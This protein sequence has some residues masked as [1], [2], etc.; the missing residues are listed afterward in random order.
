[1]S[2]LEQWGWSPAW[3]ATLKQEDP[4]GAMEPA[5]VVEEQRDGYRLQTGAG[6]VRARMSGRLRQEAGAKE[7]W[8]AVGDWVAAT[9]R[10][11][12]GTATVR[13]TLPRRSVLK[14][15]VTRGTEA[16]VVAANVDTVFVVTSLNFDFNA[17][18]MERFLTLIWEGGA[19]PVI[20]LSKAD[21][22][23]DAESRLAEA[24]AVAPGVAVHA[25]SALDGTGVDA[26]AGHLGAGRTVAL[27]GT[28]GVGKSTLVNHLIGDEVQL[29]RQIRKDAYRG[30]HTTTS[31]RLLLL[32]GGAMLVD[33]PGVREIALWDGD[34]GLQAAFED[35][36]SLVTQCRF[37]DCRH[38]SEPGCAV[39]AAVSDG[40]LAEGRYEAY[41]KLE[42]ELAH[43]E[44]RQGGRAALD[45][46]RKKHKLIEHA[47]KRAREKYR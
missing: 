24:E 5:R 35:V 42:R 12:E 20:V 41:A 14:R 25:L 6:V 7:N 17:R 37:T 16:Q 33:T 30:R 15:R 43:L 23:D 36:A 46:K 9:V 39:Q 4:E 11:D 27:I 8:P 47:R 28:S 34:E 32:E 13:R 18:R 1:M 19:Q 29:V 40:S 10:Q 31:R 26:L 2:Q 38:Q 44:R 3:A 21:L 22:C 45:E